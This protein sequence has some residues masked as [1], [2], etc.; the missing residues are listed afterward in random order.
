MS[1]EVTSDITL[2]RIMKEALTEVLEERRE[3]F[4]DVVEEVLTDFEL[5]EDIREVKK[6]ERLVHQSI[7]AVREGE[8]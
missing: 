5:V 4:R 6:T 8:A 2:K 3:F 7:F 1:Q